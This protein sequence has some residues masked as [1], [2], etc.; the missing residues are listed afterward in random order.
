MGA[1]RSTA[2][3][4]VIVTIKVSHTMRASF[5]AGRYPQ[6]RNCRNRHGSIGI[7]PEV[8]TGGQFCINGLMENREREFRTRL[9]NIAYLDR[10]V[11]Y[12]VTLGNDKKL[13]FVRGKAGRLFLPGGAMQP[14]ERPEDALMREVIEEIGWRIRILGRIG[15]ATQ[16]VSVEGEGCFLL[17]PVCLPPSFTA[18]T[19]AM[20]P[21]LKLGEPPL[22]QLRRSATLTTRSKPSRKQRCRWHCFTKPTHG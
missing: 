5:T 4:C 1:S 17:T 7:A 22:L 15:R 12:A 19:F 20:S 14:G 21:P 18:S 3:R 11:A 10:P 2:G 9:R 16:L 6:A 13:A 8:C